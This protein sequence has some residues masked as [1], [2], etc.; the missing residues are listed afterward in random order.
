MG[1]AFNLR[2]LNPS[3]GWVHNSTYSKRLIY[4]TIDYLD[5]GNATNNTVA[6]TLSGL[7]IDQTTKDRATKY[8]GIRP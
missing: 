6:A 4:D 2:L 1:A 7:S 8:I 3:S 5:D